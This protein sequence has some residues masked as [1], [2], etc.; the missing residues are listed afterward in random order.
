VEAQSGA[1]ERTVQ[2]LEP[3]LTQLQLTERARHA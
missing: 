2:S 1:L 3:Y